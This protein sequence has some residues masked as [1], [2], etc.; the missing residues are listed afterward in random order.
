MSRSRRKT[1]IIGMTL[2]E[3]DK[4]Y[5]VREH[6]AERRAGRS[7]LSAG[8]DQDDRR[9]HSKT[10]GESNFSDKDRKQYLRNSPRE[11]RK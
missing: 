8:I 7:L 3:T 10:Y 4:P 11:M 2:A 5:K 6:R 1:P 9:L